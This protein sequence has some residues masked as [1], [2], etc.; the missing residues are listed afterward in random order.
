MWG[1]ERGLAA[2]IGAT[3]SVLNWLALRWLTERIAHGEGQTKGSA[4]LLLV[5]KMGLLMALVYI[6]IQRLHVDP[7]GLAFGLGVLFIG[8]V[9]TALVGTGHSS[10]VEAR[11][12]AREQNLAG[13][14]TAVSTREEP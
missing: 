8:P 2:L 14:Q 1:A 7:I 3:L 5:G 9:V 11:D 10:K 12:S 6:L 4:S 13:A